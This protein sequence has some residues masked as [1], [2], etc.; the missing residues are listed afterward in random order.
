ML[1]AP[2]NLQVSVCFLLHREVR[3]LSYI[4]QQLTIALKVHRLGN[5]KDTKII[6]DWVRNDPDYKWREH[7]VEALAIVRS[8][9]VLRK[10][11]FELKD[12]QEAFLPHIDEISTHVHPVLKI[13]YKMCEKMRQKDRKLLIQYMLNK[14]EC[15]NFGLDG[16]NFL[17]MYL[18][19]WI[20]QKIITIGDRDTIGAE[21]GELVAFLKV[22]EIDEFYEK[23][24]RFTTTSLDATI[25]GNSPERQERNNTRPETCEIGSNMDYF[26]MNTKKMGYVV[27]F[28]EKNFHKEPNG[29]DIYLTPGNLET[30]HGTERDVSKLR[31]TFKSLG[32]C[33]VVRDDLTSDEILTTVS[34]YVE[35]TQNG[36]SSL[37]IVILSHGIEGSVYGANSVPL[38]I[39]S[40]KNVLCT[41]VP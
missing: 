6:S 21:F 24:K 33:V 2:F 37:I 30:R 35:K 36:F 22:H 40:I 32:F 17:E 29:V 3:D 27:I 39:R 16:E 18:L 25:E 28:N 31:N 41:N 7:L 15:E 1:I 8:H 26:P 20:Q 11:G 38:E 10:L 23:L 19:N 14:F 5:V 34:E 12:V 13:L 4:L 9:K